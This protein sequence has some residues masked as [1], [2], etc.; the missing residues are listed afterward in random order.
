VIIHVGIFA[1]TQP[2]TGDQVQAL[3]SAAHELP[4]RIPCLRRL[5]TGVPL[6]SANGLGDIALVAEVEDGAFDDY[7]GHPAHR[8]F[9]EKHT[10]GCVRVL[11]SVQFASEAAVGATPSREG[12]P[13]P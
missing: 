1:W 3:L 7:L 8:E 9:Q 11:G 12:D 5:D 2:P 10:K 6:D 4:E 13:R